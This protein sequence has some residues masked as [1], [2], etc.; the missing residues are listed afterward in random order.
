MIFAIQNICA[1]I[2]SQVPKEKKTQTRPLGQYTKEG[3]VNL[4]M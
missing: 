1:N 3:V 2:F 4:F